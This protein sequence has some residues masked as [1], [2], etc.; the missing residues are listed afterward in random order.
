MARRAKTPLYAPA[1]RRV[2]L[3]D[4]LRGV[5]IL[6]MVVFH[7]QWD[8]SYFGVDWKGPFDGFWELFRHA[9]AGLFILL[10]GVSLV[11]SRSRGSTSAAF[12]RRCLLRGLRI[13]GLGMVITLGSL[14]FRRESFVFFGILHFIGLAV[15][16]AAPL[17]RYTWLNLGLGLLAILLGVVMKDVRVGTPLLVWL[18]LGHPVRT[19]D[20]YPVF[21]WI[22]VVL[23][24]LFLGQMLRRSGRVGMGSPAVKAAA[25]LL[26]LGRHALLVYF[27]HLPVV[28]GAAYLLSR[29]LQ[30]P[31]RPIPTR[32]VMR[33]HE[34]DAASTGGEAG[35]AR[36][37]GARSSPEGP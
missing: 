4:L 28:F 26:L 16:I 19:L 33:M 17:T 3:V 8:M 36:G 18:G 7:L 5:A 31:P 24:G 32:R 11:L 9:T 14:L 37:G 12:S 34:Q 2:A 27:V 30:P 15:V 6:M 35:S 23:V 29:P 20:L 1:G 22:G 25:P 21:P 13:F 10:V